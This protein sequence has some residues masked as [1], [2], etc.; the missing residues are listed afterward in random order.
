M[1]IH[2]TYYQVWNFRKNMQH[3]YLLFLPLQIPKFSDVLCTVAILYS[4]G[5][6]LRYSSNQMKKKTIFFM[7]NFLI[8]MYNYFII[9]GNANPYT[10]SR[11]G[12][13][14]PANADE[15]HD[16]AQQGGRP[17]DF[18]ENDIACS[19][20][21]PYVCVRGKSL[22][23][24]STSTTLLNFSNVALY[25]ISKVQKSVAQNLTLPDPTCH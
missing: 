12:T 22:Q 4:R 24:W 5:I 2:W 21:L 14:Q 3:L 10:Y 16:C 1:F 8:I 7:K 18:T 15:A 6:F 19:T 20:C 23:R 9:S 11:W 25:S 13:N 17:T